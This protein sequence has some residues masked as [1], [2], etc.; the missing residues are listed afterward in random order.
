MTKDQT[1][2]LGKSLGLTDNQMTGKTVPELKKLITAQKKKVIQI[3]KNK[4]GVVTTPRSKGPS[5]TLIKQAKAVGMSDFQI[6]GKTERELMG[7]V[8]N[9]TIQSQINKTRKKKIEKFLRE[10]DGGDF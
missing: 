3:Q 4:S 5:P 7:L 8:G 2:T 9:R 1:L 10:L 6:E